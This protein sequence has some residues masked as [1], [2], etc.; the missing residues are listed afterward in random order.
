MLEF[1]RTTRRALPGLVG[2]L[3]SLLVATSARAI[4]YFEVGIPFG[5]DNADTFV[6]VDYEIPPDANFPFIASGLT[7][8]AIGLLSSDVINDTPSSIDRTVTWTIIN[9]APTEITEFFIFLT[10][11]QLTSFA[12]LDPNIDIDVKINDF[13]P[14]EIASYGP[15]F[16][17][18]YRLTLADFAL[19]G[20]DLIATRTFRYTVNVPEAA[21]GP[22]DFGIAY[23]SIV[24]VPEPATGLLFA[25]ALLLAAGAPRG[26]RA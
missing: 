2:L 13:D 6:A 16:F 19:I 22:P 17:A 5:F 7:S 23:T 20:E 21:S 14:M 24:S 11:L 3:F 10:A 25:G 1:L 9:N 15:Y 12:Y 18:G 8:T 26:Q 4:P